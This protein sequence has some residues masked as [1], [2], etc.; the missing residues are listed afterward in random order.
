MAVATPLPI[1]TVL[2]ELLE[3]LRR[4]PNV[5]LRAP[6]GAGKTTRVPPAV[7]D[8]G[9]ARGKQIVMLE[10]R[11]LAARAA[12]RRIAFERG[13]ELGGEV[14]WHVRFD[15]KSSRS[16]KIVVVTEGI[17]VRRLQ[18][19]PFLEDT[20]CVIFDE[21][22]ERS[23]DTD[24]SLA[25][26]R[27]LQREARP[28]LS[29]VAM[30]ATLVPDALVRYLGSAPLVESEGRLH[31]VEVRYL[32]FAER[33]PLARQLS[34][35]VAQAL[36]ST[37]GDVL[38]F[39]PGVG[40]IRRAGDELRALAERRGVELFELFGDLPA[41]QQDAVLQ[42]RARRKVVLATNVAQT[43]VTIEGVTAVVD[44][45]LARVMRFDPSV[46]LDRLLLERISRAAADQRAGR[47]G[48]TA[49]GLCLRLWDEA[50]QRSLAPEDDAEI[51]R[52]D[53]AGAALELYAWGEKDLGAFD[54]FEAPNAA[55]LERANQLLRRLGA[56]DEGGVTKLGH[57]MASLP[58]HPR[59]AR[60]LIES[61]RLGCTSRAAL[62]AALLGERDPFQRSRGPRLAAHTSSSDLL[63][64][65]Q[66]LESFEDAGT[67]S[68]DV[69]ELDRGAAYAVTRAR[70][71]LARMVE[72]HE[73]PRSA[74]LL[75]Q[76]LLA[77][78]PDRLA[79]RREPK[80]RRGVLVGGRGVTLADSSAVAEPE[81]FLCLDLDA[82]ARGERAE[83]TVRIASGVEREWLDPARVATHVDAEFDDEKERVVAFKRTT[84]DELVLDEVQAALPDAEEVARVLSAAAAQRFERVW[85]RDDAELAGFV[86]RV[87]CLRAWM[88]ELGLPEFD[89]RELAS[90]LPELCVGRRSFEELRRAPWLEFLRAKLDYKQ[91]QA[92]EREAPERL[93]VP[94]G[95]QIRLAYELGR[96]P[97]LAARIQELFGL[98]ETPRVAGGRV[99]VVMHL[100]AP[101]HRPQQITED[102]R[103]FWNTTY[104]LVAAELK[105]RYPRHAWPDDPWNATPERRPK[106]RH[107][108]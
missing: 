93:S 60:L 38:A 3:H 101:N 29:I 87:R 70:D 36:E 73:R 26:V 62:A 52:V 11:R 102:L 55:A 9:L 92:L 76:A 45:G 59:L 40:E 6:T 10:P 100:L 88:P 66:A 16:T 78:F 68:T 46:G 71:Q 15:K 24:L 4:G 75:A 63:D 42:R 98:A 50:E 13:V 80:S 81:L 2:P 30:S 41:D 95:S 67:T 53:L 57:A 27:K 1:D 108:R 96:P 25:M 32:G 106:R 65:V 31:P 103:S 56:I 107:E 20:G 12:A 17:L 5:V 84:F 61:E 19:D 28:E 72:A 99:G 39:L 105:R 8:A 83:A 64:R 94:S 54:W 43:S 23:L 44:S 82:G 51:R 104:P 58:V 49:P 22:H 18:D 33:V 7:L 74:E 97:A 14:G 86:C 85:P 89:E 47:A 69:G 90:V 35:A 91:L 34:A 77:A 21:I 48:R 37:S 79:K